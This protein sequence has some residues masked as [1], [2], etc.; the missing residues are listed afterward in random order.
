MRN[1]ETIS[2]AGPVVRSHPGI[3][4]KPVA[5]ARGLDE[6]E[7]AFAAIA[8][9]RADA[10]VVQG[11][12]FSKDVADIAIKHRL[13]TASVLRSYVDAGGLMSYG[14][15][16]GDLFRQNVVFVRKILEGAKPAGFPGEQA[17]AF[18]VALHLS[19]PE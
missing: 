12:F 6:V 19:T 11:I 15:I 9:E 16:V 17:T 5:M 10:V 18:G 14:A 1:Q 13:P 8:A 2:G 4:I 7:S 3:E